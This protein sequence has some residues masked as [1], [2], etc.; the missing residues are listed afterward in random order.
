MALARWLDEKYDAST[1][2]ALMDVGIV[3]YYSD[4]RVL[5]ITGL[6]DITIAR[7]PG[8][9]MDRVY[10]AGHIL[11]QEPAAI[12]LVSRDEDTVPDFPIDRRLHEDA[13]FQ[14]AYKLDHTLEHYRD[15]WIGDY[16]L[17]VFVRR[18]ECGTSS[19]P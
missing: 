15:L 2:V 16:V 11:D 5:D 4:L 6:T 17:L 13:R 7:S 14:A 10:D 9:I 18:G 12:V 1:A 8:R 3:G 19:Q